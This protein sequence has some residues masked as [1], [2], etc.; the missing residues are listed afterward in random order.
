MR[1][2]QELNRSSFIIRND[3]L[4]TFLWLLLVLETSIYNA[5][6]SYAKEHEGHGYENGSK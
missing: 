2:L 4:F 5:C 3:F 6:Y 1:L